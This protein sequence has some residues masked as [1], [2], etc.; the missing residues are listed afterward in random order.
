ME[1]GRLVQATGAFAAILKAVSLII[2]KFDALSK[3]AAGID[4]LD[5]FANA[6]EHQAGG[7]RRI[8]TSYARSWNAGIMLSHVTVITP[9]RKRTLAK[10]V[11]FNLSPGTSLLIV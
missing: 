9:D 4:R 7:R 6:L 1:V 5:A 11:S 10:N 8:R 2:D 3:F